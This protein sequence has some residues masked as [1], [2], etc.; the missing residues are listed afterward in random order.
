MFVTIFKLQHNLIQIQIVTLT[1][2]PTLIL[3]AFLTFKV[4]KI[5]LFTAFLKWKET[6]QQYNFAQDLQ[7]IQLHIRTH[8]DQMSNISYQYLRKNDLNIIP[9]I[10]MLQP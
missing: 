9:N 7:K 8:H 4:L 3:H 6:E 10:Y 1:L 2:S 5:A